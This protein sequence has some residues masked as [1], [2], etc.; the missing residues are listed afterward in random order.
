M[1]GMSLTA[2]QVCSVHDLVRH[3]SCCI[4]PPTCCCSL[5]GVCSCAHTGKRAARLCASL[6]LCDAEAMA[7]SPTCNMWALR[8][9]PPVGDQ[10]TNITSSTLDKCTAEG[11]P[12]GMVLPGVAST[13]ALPSNTCDTDKDCSEG[14]I[15]NRAD[16]MLRPLCSCFGGNDV[17]RLIGGGFPESS[18]HL[19][20][21]FRHVSL[22][23][24]SSP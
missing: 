1:L 11:L 2:Q 3:C 16:T 15:C 23:S 19:H 6:G 14:T 24:T 9:L 21:V 10:G 20:A 13:D 4:P 22:R 8:L 12:G 5:S 18:H 17:C 7:A